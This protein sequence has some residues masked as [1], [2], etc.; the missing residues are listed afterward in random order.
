MLVPVPVPVGVPVL[1]PGGSVVDEVA[2][3]SVPESVS[4]TESVFVTESVSVTVSVSVA[5]SVS[6]SE[7]GSVAVVGL[8][9]LDDVELPGPPVLASG[10]AVVGNT[11]PVDAGGPSVST[12]NGLSSMQPAAP[13][14]R[15]HAAEARANVC[16][17][18]RT[19]PAIQRSSV[20]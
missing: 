9:L 1:V 4:V 12:K 10:V 8:E 17:P 6:V 14:I 2:S 20:R 5:V 15:A 16:S 3:V 19:S 11:S 13:K 7:V 18:L